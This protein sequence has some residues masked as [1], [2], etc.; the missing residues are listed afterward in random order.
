MLPLKDDPLSAESLVDDHIQHFCKIHKFTKR[1][2]KPI[3]PA[4]VD[5]EGLH[6]IEG[7]ACKMNVSLNMIAIDSI[8]NHHFAESLGIDIKNMKNMT[9][10]VILDTKVSWI[11]ILDVN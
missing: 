10:V 11:L 5:E 6:S 2:G 9:A 4:V 1:R 7:L 3:F 8:E